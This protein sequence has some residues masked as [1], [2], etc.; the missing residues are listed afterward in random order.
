MGAQY[1]Q[2]LENHLPEGEGE[3]AAAWD[4]NEGGVEPVGSSL[5]RAG[6]PGTGTLV[7]GAKFFGT[8]GICGIL[9]LGN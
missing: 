7:L 8:P 6:P 1:N 2:L 9:V 4:L 5:A 3:L